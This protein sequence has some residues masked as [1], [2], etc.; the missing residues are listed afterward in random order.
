MRQHFNH[1]LKYLKTPSLS[2]WVTEIDPEKN[3]LKH[4]SLHRTHLKY[5]ELSMITADQLQVCKLQGFE[6]G[7]Y[8]VWFKNRTEGEMWLRE[9]L[10]RW[11]PLLKFGWVV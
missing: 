9:F 7:G 4:M 8:G 3:I 1:G 5:V 11:S 2:Y 6:K 10:L